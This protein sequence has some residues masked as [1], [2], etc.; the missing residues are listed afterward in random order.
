MSNNLPFHRKNPV[1]FE[2]FAARAIAATG[3]S[4]A[5]GAACL[6]VVLWGASGPLLGFSPTWQIAINT[7]T[8]IVTF[9]MVFLLQQTHN[10][11][12]IAIHLKLN[13]LLASHETAS[14]R[15]IAIEELGAEELQVLRRFYAHLAELSEREGGVKHTHSLDEAVQSHA[16]K[17]ERRGRRGVSGAF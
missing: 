8:T 16:R 14:N 1:G 3:S 17:R 9:L 12:S 4:R 10:K 11:D 2:R 6:V 13:E 7:L 5:F 15:V